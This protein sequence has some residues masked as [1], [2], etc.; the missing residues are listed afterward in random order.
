MQLFSIDILNCYGTIWGDLKS[1]GLFVLL[2]P[3]IEG[4]LGISLVLEDAQ[5]VAIAEGID[6]L[7]Q[8]TAN[9][10]EDIKSHITSA[11]ISP[12]K[13]LDIS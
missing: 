10:K 11:L 2:V 9:D 3:G 7:S 13:T 5:Q 4:L 12:H 6:G 8:A 1:P